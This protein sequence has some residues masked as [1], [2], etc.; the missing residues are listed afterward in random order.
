[1]VKEYSYLMNWKWTCWTEER[2]GIAIARRSTTEFHGNACDE[3]ISLC[4]SSQN[5]YNLSHLFSC[6]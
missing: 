4:F 2:A 5:A 1:M 3:N 6:R